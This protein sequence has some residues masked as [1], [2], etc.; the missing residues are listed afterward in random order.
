MGFFSNLFKTKDAKTSQS[1]TTTLPGWV[2]TPYQDLITQAQQVGAQDVTPEEQAALDYIRGNAGSYQGY[3]DQAAGSTSN[4][5]NKILAGPQTADIQAG[6]NPYLD[7]ILNQQRREGEKTFYGDMARLRDQ[8]V[9][10]GA[11]GGS[12]GAVAEQTLQD[13]YADNLASTNESALFNA[14]ETARNQY[15][16]NNQMGL[17]GSTALANLG[18]QGQAGVLN[19][20]NAMIQAGGYGRGVDQ[21]NINMLNNVIGQAAETMKGSDTT[22][23]EQAAEG[24]MFSKILGTVASIA[25]MASGNPMAAMGMGSM[26][27]GGGGSSSPMQTFSS[28]QGSFSPSSAG[29]IF[30]NKYA[31]GGLVE[32]YQDGGLVDMPDYIRNAPDLSWEEKLREY[33]REI[34]MQERANSAPREEAPSIPM[35]SINEDPTASRLMDAVIGNAVSKP[36]RKPSVIETTKL[37][38]SGEMTPDQVAFAQSRNPG[39]SDVMAALEGMSPDQINALFQMPASELPT[40]AEGGLVGMSADDEL[41][42]WKRNATPGL[43]EA[44]AKASAPRRAGAVLGGG[45]DTYVDPQTLLNQAIGEQTDFSTKAFKQNALKAATKA[46][47]AVDR[48]KQEMQQELSNSVDT[49]GM[50]RLES[51]LAKTASGVNKASAGANLLV[52]APANAGIGIGRWLAE[53]PDEEVDAETIMAG[54]LPVR[55]VGEVATPKGAMIPVEKIATSRQ[56]AKAAQQAPTSFRQVENAV[57]KNEEEGG[58]MNIPLIMAGIALMTS[59]SDPFSSM[60]EGLAAYL[61]GKQME[62]Q[63]KKEA[64]KEARA[65]ALA[66]RTMQVDEGK[67]DIMKQQ[68]GLEAKKIAI[69]AKKAGQSGITPD[70]VQDDVTN[71]FKARVDALSAAVVPGQKIDMNQVLDEAYNDSVNKVMMSYTGQTPTNAVKLTPLQEMM[72]AVQQGPKK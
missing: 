22:K 33:Q 14:F 25:G 63:T 6:M 43:M 48:H 58:G 61:G 69:E 36:R 3:I 29:S 10:A 32:G 9:N 47:G 15:N 27:G 20:G 18:S 11:F 17:T 31:H 72:Q 7:L 39:L 5:L 12:R 59:T 49:T 2:Q 52:A 26:F 38:T 71:L 53:V 60:G 51:I 57:E 44:L 34:E 23:T 21:G 66:E 70:K 16:T 62:A 45:G 4:L 40:F 30:W 56:E 42:Y 19:T 67:L 64:A 55:E 24:S 46:V 1:T 37:K 50:N 28:P 54:D 41:D 8:E 65:A 13:N 35:P 68:L